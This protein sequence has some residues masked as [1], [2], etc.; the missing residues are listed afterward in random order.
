MSPRDLTLPE[1][2]PLT[3]QLKKVYEMNGLSPTEEHLYREC[4]G[5]KSAAG[6][7]K[8]KGRRGEIPRESWL[9][10]CHVQVSACACVF[11]RAYMNDS[12]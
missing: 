4:W 11:F 8:R 10:Q 2:K 3:V 12:I 6:F 7:I 9:N 5:I 1:I